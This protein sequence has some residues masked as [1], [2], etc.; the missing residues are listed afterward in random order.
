MLVVRAREREVAMDNESPRETWRKSS[1]S[2]GGECVEVRIE[3]RAVRV[4]NSRD[5]EGPSI[6]FTYSEWHAFLAGVTLGEFEIDQYG[7][8]N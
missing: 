1:R 3:Q 8:Q 7:D 5:P 4:R 2:I 6:S